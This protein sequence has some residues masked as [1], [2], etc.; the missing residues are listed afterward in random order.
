MTRIQINQTVNLSSSAKLELSKIK[1]RIY[2]DNH[3]DKPHNME[4]YPRD[5]KHEWFYYEKPCR[6]F[7]S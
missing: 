4:K 5:V 7:Q 3:T 6:G 2:E 1:E